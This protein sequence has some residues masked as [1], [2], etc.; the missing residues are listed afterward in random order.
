VTLAALRLAVAPAE[1]GDARDVPVD[2]AVAGRVPV[3]RLLRMAADRRVVALVAGAPRVSGVELLHAAARAPESGLDLLHLTAVGIGARYVEA[4]AGRAA[5]TGWAPHEMCCLAAEVER[6]M[7]TWVCAPGLS[8]WR[9][10]RPLIGRR[11]CAVLAAGRWR[12]GGSAPAAT[13]ELLDRGLA[14]SSVCLAA[15][16]G[17][18][19]RWADERL[20]SWRRSGAVA[21]RLD[22]GLAHELGLRW[23]LEL[24]V[25]PA[26]TALSLSALREQV[27][28]APR[29]G[30]CRL[31]VLG[32]ACSRCAVE[33]VR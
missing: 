32:T 6:R 30:W 9:L 14:R 22:R 1:P 25:A 7:T 10:R 24:V 18:P 20:D 15:V 29:C 16:S 23:T 12:P 8:L 27:A 17:A 4:V 13:A 3:D 21:G 19:G 5:S 2:V 28:S 11:P 33:D 31:P 26:L